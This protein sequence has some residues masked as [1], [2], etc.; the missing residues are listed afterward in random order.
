MISLQKGDLFAIANLVTFLSTFHLGIVNAQTKP[1]SPPIPV[2]L[3]FGHEQLNFQLIVKKKF[4]PESKFDLLVISVFSEN[5]DKNDEM[6]NSVVIPFQ[7]N[8]NIGKKGFALAAGGEGNS[9]VGFSPLVGVEHSFA[10]RKVLA[11]TVLNYLINE[12][13]DLKLFGLYEYKP[14]INETWSWYSRIQFV[15]NHSFAENSHNR[16]F[17]YLRAGVKKGPLGFGLG[18]NWDQYGPNRITKDNFGVFTRWEF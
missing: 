10:N 14:P 12:N 8:Y 15:Y 5:W 3:V 1:M 4:T 9:V 17:L 13:Q 11:I 16:S 18:A 6:G 2:E 7:V